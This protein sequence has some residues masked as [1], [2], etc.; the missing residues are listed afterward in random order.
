MLTSTTPSTTSRILRS[1]R[2]AGKAKQD[3]PP[4]NTGRYAT[5][6]TPGCDDDL[7]RDVPP[8]NQGWYAMPVTTGHDDESSTR[9][10]FLITRPRSTRL[11]TGK[12]PA[13]ESASMV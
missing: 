7:M 3:V 1:S 8:A 6:A 5:P 12:L 10:P 2:S 11:S 4:A 9:K 13:S